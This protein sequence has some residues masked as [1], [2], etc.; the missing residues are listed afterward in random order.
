MPA[1]AKLVV[2]L[3]CRAVTWAGDPICA[4]FDEN[5]T[6]PVGA[7]PYCPVTVAVN[8]TLWPNDDGFTVFVKPVAVVACVTLIDT[9]AVAVV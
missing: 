4:P 3:A 8:V 6:V 2:I 1:P 7:A 5:V 9:V